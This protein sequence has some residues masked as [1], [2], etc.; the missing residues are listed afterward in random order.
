MKKNKDISERLSVLESNIEFLE[1]SLKARGKRTDWIEEAVLSLLKASV[2][3]IVIGT[4]GIVNQVN[5]Y[6]S[7]KDLVG[8][9]VEYLGLEVVHTEATTELKKK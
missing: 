6:L 7:V 4:K 1:G 9:V 8:L 2:T 3:D 5:T